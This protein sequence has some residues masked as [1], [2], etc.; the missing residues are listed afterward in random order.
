MAVQGSPAGVPRARTHQ[1]VDRP[2]AEAHRPQAE[3]HRPR[4]EAGSLRV[5]AGSLRIGVDNRQAWARGRR[6]RRR[7]LPGEE[8]RHW[9]GHWA[10]GA[11]PGRLLPGEEGRRWEDLEAAIPGSLLAVVGSPRKY[12][13]VVA[14]SQGSLPVGGRPD[15]QQGD[16]GPWLEA[17]GGLVNLVFIRVKDFGTDGSNQESEFELN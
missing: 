4:A 1:E 6:R 2:Q 11:N 14:G 10:A 5:G 13:E 15:H 16:V 12:L 3:A 8:G 17:G 9:E 7:L